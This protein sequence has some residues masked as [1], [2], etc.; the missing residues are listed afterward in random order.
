MNNNIGVLINYK[1]TTDL[2]AEFKKAQDMELNSCQLCVWDMTIYEDEKYADALK[3]AIAETGFNVTALW[4]GWSGPK[5]WNFTTG[6]ATIG[7]VP[8]TY[9]YERMRDLIKGSDF[10]KKVG[11]TKVI[12]HAGFIPENPDHPDFTGT[13]A[14]LRYVI[15]T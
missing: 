9:R 2:V 14:A 13:V 4:A 5:E 1:P 11:I 7:L 12:T 10:A 6:P 15:G 3:A 8:T